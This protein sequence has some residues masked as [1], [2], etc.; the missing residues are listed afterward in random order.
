MQEK[1]TINAVK[2]SD[3]IK[4]VYSV[5]AY[6]EEVDKHLKCISFKNRDDLDY[7][8]YIVNSDIDSAYESFNISKEIYD[9]NKIFIRHIGYVNVIVIDEVLS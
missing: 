2:N 9:L 8:L 5:Y 3:E 4:D 7:F 1:I 6:V